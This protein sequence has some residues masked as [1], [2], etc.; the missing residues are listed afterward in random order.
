LGVIGIVPSGGFTKV[1]IKAKLPTSFVRKETK[2][3]KVQPWLQEME[4][5]FKIQ[6]LKSD[7]EQ[8]Q[9]A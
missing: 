1:A 9:F 6:H 4:V 7:K 2:T 3:K 8:I 5:Y